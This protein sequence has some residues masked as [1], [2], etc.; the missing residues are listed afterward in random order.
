M[1]RTCCPDA[2]RICAASTALLCLVII[3]ATCQQIHAART[4]GSLSIRESVK[5]TPVAQWHSLFNVEFNETTVLLFKRS[6]RGKWWYDAASRNEV[7]YRED[8]RGDRYCGS[9]HAFKST[10]CTHLVTAGN[11]YLIFPEL[12]ECCLC[13]NAADGC[14]ILSPQWL[15]NS[16]YQGDV[17]LRG[18]TTHKF[19]IKGLQP[20]YYFTTA[21]ELQ[22]PVELDQWPNVY[23]SFDPST[24][25][26]EPID[27][28]MLEVPDNCHSKCPISSICTLISSG[29]LLD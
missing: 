13:C 15:Q 28:T 8:G 29:V 22:L 5:E 21:D 4:G 7:V 14:G 24:F 25:N 10:P 11:R 2:R 17:D 3:I 1:P 27:P 18:I 20:N 19:Y 6:T 12:D 23:Q 26:T 9:I 16:T